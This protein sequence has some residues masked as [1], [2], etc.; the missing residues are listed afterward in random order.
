M[1]AYFAAHRTA[2]NL[3]MVGVIVLGL[4]AAPSIKRG[5]FPDVPPD[6][7]EIQVLYPGANAEKVEE[8]VCQRIED[9]LEKVKDMEEVRC[10]ARENRGMATAKMIE[11]KNFDSFLNDIKTEVEAIDNFPDQAEAPVIRQLGVTDFVAA[12][13]ITGPMSAPHLKAYAEEL[14][15]QMLAGRVTSQVRIGG[16]SDH[17]IRIEIPARSLRQYGISVNDIAGVI[18]R[19]SVDL[20]AGA[21]ETGERDLLI[22]FADERRRPSEFKNLVVVGAKSGAELR[23]GDIAA[24][25]DR[26]ET[27]ED[28]VIF[29][30]QRAAILELTKTKSEDTLTVI[31]AVRA[32]IHEKKQSAPAG[33]KFEITRDLSSIVRDRLSLL[34][35]NGFQGLVLVLLT[36]WLFFSLRFSFW[37]AMGFPVSF[38]GAIAGMALAGMSFDMITMV[39]LLIAIGLLVDDAI[40]IAE[41]IA[42]HSKRGSPP[43]KAAIDGTRQVAPG[44]IASYLSTI[45]VFGSLMFLKGEIGAILKFLPMILILTL[46]VSLIEAFLILPHH[47]A[48]A[49]TGAGEDP[50]GGLRHRLERGIDYLRE[51]VL[52]PSSPRPSNG[53]ISAW[54]WRP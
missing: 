31:D 30:H 44:V 21:I 27:A 1:I 36:L 53:A 41:N 25:T 5:T 43:L 32:F 17:Q 48:G 35:R 50:D 23:L 40:V 6:E 37:V 4:I 29:N 28:K 33:V 45:C 52:S 47:M 12:L 54:D 9:A 26:F 49:L 8:A 38:L 46:S 15:D 42:A 34:V 7:V 18:A 20:P 19:Q 24:I 2:A 10:E 13:A 16:F 22:R 39:G 3:L 14:K 51:R 11:G